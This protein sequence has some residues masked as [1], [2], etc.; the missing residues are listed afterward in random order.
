MNGENNYELWNSH[1]QIGLNTDAV[2][3]YKI[4]VILSTRQNKTILYK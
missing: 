3:A 2:L 1:K 4:C